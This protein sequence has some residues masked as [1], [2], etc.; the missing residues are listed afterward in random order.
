MMSHFKKEFK[1]NSAPIC[2]TFILDLKLK[3]P[4]RGAVD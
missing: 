1:N 3:P 2:I 4:F